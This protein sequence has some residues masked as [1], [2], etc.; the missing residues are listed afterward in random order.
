[1]N[2]LL[3]YTM[4]VFDSFGQEPMKED[5]VQEEMSGST[6]LQNE[7]ALKNNESSILEQK[8]EQNIEPT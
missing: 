2:I 1:M 5:S 6:T 7:E 3:L 4:T 8:K